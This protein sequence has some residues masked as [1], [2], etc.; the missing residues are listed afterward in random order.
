MTDIA[1]I[2]ERQGKYFNTGKTLDIAFRKASLDRLKTAIL[3]M[4]TEILQALN[5]DLGKCECE[6]YMTEVGMVLNEISYMRKNIKR[7]AKPKKV[8][9]PLSQFPAKSFTVPVPYGVVLIMSPW[10]YPFTLALD[11]LIDALAAGNTAVVKPSAY[12]PASSA[13]IKK[14]ISSCFPAEYVSVIEGGREA[15]RE[16]LDQKFDYIF[17][18]GGKNVGRLVMEKAARYLTPVTL[19]LGGKSP[20]IVDDTANLKIAA[21]RI[22]FGKFLNV[23][24][25]CVAPDYLLVQENIKDKLLLH[26]KDEIRQQF[27]ENPLDNLT[28]GKI[29]NDKHFNRLLGLIKGEKAVIGGRYNGNYRIEPTVL[30]NITLESPIM[31]EEIF[32]PVL[33]VLTFKTINEAIEIVSRNPTPLALYLFSEDKNTERE[34]LNRV[35]FGGGCINDTI[36]HLA[37]NQMGFGGVGE[38]GHGSYHGKFGFDTFSHY[39]SIVKQGTVFDIP[40]RYRPYDAKKLKI[41]KWFLK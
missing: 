13:V 31:Q 37:T 4:E 5:E 17:F 30:D 29:I 25:T 41:L 1:G 40:I 18:T 32:G 26:L 23:G 10:N 27:G 16:L 33:P 22:V 14:L 35:S 39:K 28:Y 11:P 12:S 20:C 7:F 34:I 8:G 24:Q 19:E 36:V 38:S 2:V 21:A 15:N 6:G 9:T 3:G